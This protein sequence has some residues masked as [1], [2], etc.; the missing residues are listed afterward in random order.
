MPGKMNKTEG[1][2]E[3]KSLSLDGLDTIASGS[4]DD[5]MKLTRTRSDGHEEIRRRAQRTVSE[6]GSP[7]SDPS[8]EKYIAL[9]AEWLSE[10][11]RASPRS[12]DYLMLKS[13]ADAQVAN[14]SSA[15]NRVIILTER[16]D[17]VLLQLNAICKKLDVPATGGDAGLRES[18]RARNTDTLMGEILSAVQLAEMAAMST[19]K[20]LKKVDSKVDLLLFAMDQMVEM[21]HEIKEMRVDMARLNECMQAIEVA[22]TSSASGNEN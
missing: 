15:V 16:F 20:E 9:I 14:A 3:V 19:A 7:N 12:K 22:A 21:R 4:D 1:E 5:S 17:Q 11:R 10:I 18:E 13:R 6:S 2:K 8:A